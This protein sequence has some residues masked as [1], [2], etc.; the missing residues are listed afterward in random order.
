MTDLARI[1]T[2]LERIAAA[3]ESRPIAKPRRRSRPL[4][5]AELAEVNR[6]V[7]AGLARRGEVRR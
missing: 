7:D 5:T 2:A 6:R 4:S 1:A 3:L